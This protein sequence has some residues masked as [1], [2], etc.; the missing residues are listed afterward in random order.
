MEDLQKQIAEL[1]EQIRGI[2]NKIDMLLEFRTH[3]SR[4]PEIKWIEHWTPPKGPT[5]QTE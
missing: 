2:N 3:Y 5:C 1:Q 4:A